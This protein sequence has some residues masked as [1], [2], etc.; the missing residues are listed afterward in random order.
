[1]MKGALLF[2]LLALWPLS[3]SAHPHAFI[4]IRSTLH[5]NAAGELVAISEYW[6]FD[7]YYTE[8]ALDDF[9][10]NPKLKGQEA[11]L[12][13]LAAE[14]LHNL[15]EFNYFTELKVGEK[16]IKLPKHTNVKSYLEGKQL[17]MEFTLPL[18][19]PVAAPLALRIFDP[20]Y[21]TAMVYLEQN[22]VT[23][24]AAPHCKVDIAHPQPDSVWTTLASGLDKN[25]T[26]PDDLG[27]YFAEKVSVICVP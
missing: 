23:L 4:D 3:A 7:Q 6:R 10:V 16:S 24:D 27:S 20:S 11:K 13:E 19:K 1:M 25:A 18:E 26:A 5:F 22:P 14:N 17:V 15:K 2:L 12:L 21:Y 8:F 9:K